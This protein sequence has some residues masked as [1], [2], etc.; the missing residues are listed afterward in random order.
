MKYAP[1]IVFVYNRA[2]LAKETLGALDTCEGSQESDLFIFSDGSKSSRENNAVKEVREYIKEYK[3]S[4]SFKHTSLILQ[5]KNKGLAN[6]VIDGVT[7]I[8]NK[9][10]KVIVVEDDCL[11][12]PSFINYMNRALDYYER[13]ES[14]GSITGWSPNIDYPAGYDADIFSIARSCSLCWGTWKNRWNRV[15]W[16]MGRFSEIRYDFKL[17]KKINRAGSDR[18]YRLIRQMKYDVQS[19]SV[20]FGVTLVMNDQNTIYPRYS[21]VRNIGGDG[22]GTHPAQSQLLESNDV[23]IEKAIKNPKFRKVKP[24]RAIEKQI[25]NYYSGD[26]KSKIFR[27]I[28]VHGGEKI[29]DRLLHRNV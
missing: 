29:I 20:R 9:Y 7:S 6:S 11:V 17:I 13:D 5:D 25:S 15:D 24:I 26:L 10:G 8:I 16:D 1:I 2:D 28:Y 3:D 21:Y 14:I 22:R 4:N 27:W 23:T 19:W 12:A 18:F